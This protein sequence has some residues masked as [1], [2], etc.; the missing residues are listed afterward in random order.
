MGGA[1]AVE[2]GARNVF[3]ATG[4]PHPPAVDPKRKFHG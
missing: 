4:K 1:A 3:A 2:N